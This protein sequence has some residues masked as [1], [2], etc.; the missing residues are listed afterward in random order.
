MLKFQGKVV[1]ITGS[2][3][4]IGKAIAVKFAENGASIVILGRRKEPLE[5]T[6][7]SLREII[8]KVSSNAFVKIFGGVD[9]SGNKVA[10]NVTAQQFWQAGAS[11]TTGQRYGVGEFF[12]YDATNFRVRELS[13]G[14]NI[15]LPSGTVFKSIGFRRT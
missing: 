8:N 5:E 1:V 13:I 12:A 14:Y 11:S 4:G 3:T 10:T 7:K 9:V 15:P 6:A 2:G